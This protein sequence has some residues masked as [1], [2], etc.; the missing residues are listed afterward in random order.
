[1][2]QTV[3]PL[4]GLEHLIAAPQ[5]ARHW[6]R[7][8]LLTNPSGVTRD[9][10]PAALALQRAGIPLVKLF[11]PEHGVDGSGA[12]GEAPEAGQDGATGLPTSV[13][14]H[15]T[16]EE[17]AQRLSGLDT[18]LI[19]LQDVGVRFYTYISTIRDV[20]RAARTLPLRVVVLDRPNPIGFTVE[21]P[22][23]HPDFRSFVGVTAQLPLRHGLTL[24]EVARVLAAEEGSTV[25]VIETDAPNGW[26]A[27]REWVPS[28]PNLPDL[29][30]LRLYPGACL[31]EALDASEGR[32]TALPFRQFGAPTLNA[33]A[34][35]ERLNAL[36]LGVTARPAFFNPTTSKHRGE[37]CA[38]VQLHEN[39]GELRRALPLGLA[40]FAALEE[41]GARRNPDWLQKL[42]GVTAGS[43][44]HTPE[45]V[46]SSLRDW[47]AQGHQQALALRP[48]WLYPRQETD[49]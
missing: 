24:G 27:G 16:E 49:L 45:E 15:L 42:L 14:Y 23:L 3:G 31:I 47:Q 18:L 33:H 34:L 8:A 1:M 38:G 11:G 43:V 10:T 32:G 22:P 21:G 37:R 4:I 12:P 48:H 39:R 40:L 26:H 28:S 25:E 29:L 13:L 44:P 19:D 2:T 9:L 6:G 5:Q 46:L 36:N 20:L 30:H 7:T 41:A 35:A 17:Y